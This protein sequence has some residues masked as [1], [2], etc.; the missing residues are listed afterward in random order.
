MRNARFW[1]LAAVIVTAAGG[2]SLAGAGTALAGGAAG[3]DLGVTI[4]A[5]SAFVPVTGDTLVRFGGPAAQATATVSGSVSGIPAGL[6]AVNVTLLAKPFH[7][8]AFT[9]QATFLATAAADGTAAYSFAVMPELATSYEVEVSAFGSRTVPE[10]SAPQTVYVIPDIT[11]AGST[12]CS[13]PKCHSNLTITARFPAAAFGDEAHKP[14]KVYFGIRE[15]PDR[16]PAGPAEL[17]LV[18]PAQT[19]VPDA[20]L[21]ATR[22]TVTLPFTV[23]PADGYQWKINYCTVGTESADGLGLPGQHGCG[24]ST[25]SATA[26]YLG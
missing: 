24:G 12:K 23:G 18:G 7:A 17:T 4:D 8:T 14:L 11:V 10:T 16:T 22:Y 5:T 13:R 1:R 25:V 15:L 21:S 3:H 26:A 20:K 9:K 19:A 6:A 2:L